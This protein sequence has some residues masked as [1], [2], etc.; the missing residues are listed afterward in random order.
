M[1]REQRAALIG[2][3]LR[4]L[5]EQGA[6]AELRALKTS[7]G[8]LSGYFND[9]WLLADAAAR[10]SG[11]APGVYITI[12][13]VRRDLLA[14]AANRLVP[15]AKRTT[16]DADIVRRRWFGVDFDAVRPAGISATDGEHNAALDRAQQAKTW[17]Q[18]QGFPDPIFADSGNGGHLL[19]KIDLPNDKTSAKLLKRCLN[20]L[21]LRLNDGK[22]EVDPRTFNASR[23]WKVYG[24]LAAKGTNTAHR[25]HRRAALVHVPASIKTVRPA[26]LEQLA[27]T[28]SQPENRPK[29]KLNLDPNAWAKESAPIEKVLDRLENVRPAGRGWSACC[30]GHADNRPSLS[31]AEGH[32]GRVLV[33]CFAGCGIE[34]ILAAL[35]LDVC[36]LFPHPQT[37]IPRKGKWYGPHS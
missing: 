32:D 28:V 6:V 1:T 2:K 37:K 7:Q 35:S 36:D 10:V 25:P 13:P 30:P 17:L 20:A 27:A 22:V 31:I 4:V 3:G 12:N 18:S 26:L 8:T 29:K 24:T 23:I 11:K 9:K 19:F 21:A 14:R 34:E 5:L 16:T 15:Y 33:Y